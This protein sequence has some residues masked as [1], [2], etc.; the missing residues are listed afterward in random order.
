MNPAAPKP[1]ETDSLQLHPEIRARLEQELNEAIESYVLDVPALRTAP[2]VTPQEIRASLAPFDFSQ[3]V[4]P[5]R[6][7]QFVVENL[8]KNQVHPSHPRYF[9]LF[10][11]SPTTMGIV[12]DTLVAAFN[13]Q[14]AVWGHN[15]FSVE[16]ERH[17]IQSLGALF[18]YASGEADGTLATGG[19]EANHTALLASLTAAF[20]DFHEK[21]LRGLKAQ[22]VFYVSAEGHHSFQKMSRLTGLGSEAIR[23]IPVNDQLQM[24]MGILAEQIQKDRKAGYAPFLI[25]ATAGTTNAG[26]IDPLPEIAEI[27]VKEKLWLHADAAW[28]G[29]LALAPRYRKLL[30]GIDRADSITFD[31]HKWLSV[32]VGAGIFLTRHPDILS[33]TFHISAAYV[34]PKAEGPGIVDPIAHSI[35]WSRRFIGLKIFLSLAVAGWEGYARNIEHMAAMGNELRRKLAASQWA[36]IFPNPLPIVCFV[37]AAHREGRSAEY[38]EAIVREVVASGDAWISA[39]KLRRDVPV[40]RACITNFRTGPEDLQGLIDSL[41]RARERMA[42]RGAGHQ[43]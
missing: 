30:A 4:D 40:L 16:V 29:A 39:T 17:L 33:R 22:P 18:G 35:Q 1:K 24:D 6:A 42:G 9:G 3:P 36:E 31:A 28:E 11:P 34:P 25:V 2:R 10:N 8:R 5:S 23:E 20:P 43:P 38:L 21:G 7:L 27:A 14:L 37:D 26:A 15:P 19:S 12:A 13:P 32:P 41:E